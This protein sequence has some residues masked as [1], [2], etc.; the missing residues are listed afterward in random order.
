MNE[1]N[2]LDEFVRLLRNEEII[3]QLVAL[4]SE[5]SSGT[6]SVCLPKSA[7]ERKKNLH[8]FIEAGRQLNSNEEVAL[9]GSIKE[10]LGYDYTADEGADICVGFLR[11]KSKEIGEGIYADTVLLTRENF[12][13]KIIENFLNT[14]YGNKKISSNGGSPRKIELN[15]MLATFEEFKKTATVEEVERFSKAVMAQVSG[16]NL[17]K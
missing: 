16:Q 9:M 17:T 2:Q 6:I 1:P 11:L 5:K 7:V 15:E 8:F 14:H 13:K 4:V 3:N 12:D 10:K